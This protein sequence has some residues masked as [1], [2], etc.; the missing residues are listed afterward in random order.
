VFRSQTRK[1]KILFGFADAVLTAVA[2]TFAYDVR[3]YLPLTHQ[4]FLTPDVHTLLLGFCLL[5]WVGFGF[6]FNVYGKLE[7]VRIRVIL[8]DSIRQVGSG[9]L[10]LV[11][12]IYGR[13]GQSGMSSSWAR[14]KRRWRWRAVSKI[15]TGM[16]CGYSGS[17]RR[18]VE[19]RYPPLLKSGGR[20]ACFR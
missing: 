8:A 2:F 20:I 5:T 10:A 11:V 19:V 9:A 6:R 18:R 3:E 16:E 1:L 4:F 12:L 7:F 13:W 17:L 15:F 14:G